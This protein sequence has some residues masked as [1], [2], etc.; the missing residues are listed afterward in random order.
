MPER[1][2]RRSTNNAFG[3]SW[4]SERRLKKRKFSD[5]LHDEP[6]VVRTLP[7]KNA[8][9]GLALIGT[10]ETSYCIQAKIHMQQLPLSYFDLSSIYQDVG[11][12]EKR[13][14]SSIAYPR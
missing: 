9:F 5:V 13:K 11:R 3:T 6:S 1:G 14:H 4:E 8:G 12:F 2:R 10:L 7:L